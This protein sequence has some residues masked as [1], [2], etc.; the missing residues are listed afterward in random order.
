MAIPEI[1]QRYLEEKKRKNM[2]SEGYVS[3]I[4]PLHISDETELWDARTD[5]YDHLKNS[6][7]NRAQRAGVT[8]ILGSV[9]YVIRMDEQGNFL[10]GYKVKVGDVRDLS[11]E[12]LLK[13]TGK[14]GVKI[15]RA[16]FGRK[17]ES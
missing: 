2:G 7:L 5:A 12:Q 3:K 9:G 17:E 10:E 13:L 6:G 14:K 4:R 16:L 1:L 8:N 11:D 15:I